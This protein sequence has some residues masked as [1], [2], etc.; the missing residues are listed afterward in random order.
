MP[1]RLLRDPAYSIRI[2]VASIFSIRIIVDGLAAAAD[3][4][5]F[6][7]NIF[8][9]SSLHP[10]AANVQLF[11]ESLQILHLCMIEVAHDFLRME[12]LNASMHHR[13][14]PLLQP[15]RPASVHTC[16]ANPTTLQMTCTI[17]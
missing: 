10:M 3:P 15:E 4:S 14:D 16:Y 13:M 8:T 5:I 11:A 12:M 6:I 9:K 2:V 7:A 17:E 1:L